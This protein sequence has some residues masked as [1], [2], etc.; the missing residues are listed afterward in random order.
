MSYPYFPARH[1]TPITSRPIR[2]VVIHMMEAPEKPGTALAV[3]KWFASDAAPQASAHYCVDSVEIVQSVK[4]Q[5]I[6]WGAPGAN[7]DGIHIEHA[8]YASQNT[9]QWDDPYSAAMLK[10]SA[11]LT[12]EICERWAI[13]LQWLTVEQVKDGET[14]GICGHVDVTEAFH[15]STHTDPGKNFPKDRYVELVQQSFAEQFPL[16]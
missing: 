15:L 6:A 8:G 10:L 4:E 16:T 9:E 13:P 11:K 2:L 12:A 5:Y 7:R 3:A 1:F 14:R